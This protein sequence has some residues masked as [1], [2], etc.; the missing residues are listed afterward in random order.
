VY[1]AEFGILIP[2]LSEEVSLDY[3]NTTKGERFL[4]EAILYAFKRDNVK[5]TVERAYRNA[6][7]YD[8]KAFEKRMSNILKI[9]FQN[10]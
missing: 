9:V 1:P 2:E 8:L 4:A 10:E 3:S 5:E 7:Q 6:V